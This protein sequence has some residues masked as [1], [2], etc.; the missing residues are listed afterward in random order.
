MSL[1][2]PPEYK[3][4][5]FH[6]LYCNVK[7]NQSWDRAYS[8][9]NWLIQ[10]N[11]STLE[12]SYCSHCSQPTLWLSEKIIYPHAQIFP[13]PNNDLNNEVKQVYQEAAAIAEKSPRAACALLRLAIE[14]LLKQLGET[15]TLNE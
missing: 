15:G 14:M 7:A 4:R 10:I 2:F 3:S 9:N 8:S 6:C 13:L 5:G 1:Y 11:N 12:F